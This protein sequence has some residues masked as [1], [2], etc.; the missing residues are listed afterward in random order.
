M[1]LSYGLLECWNARIQAVVLNIE[2]NRQ[3]YRQGDRQADSSTIHAHKEALRYAPVLPHGR[4]L[5]DHL[6]QLPS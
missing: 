2:D 4:T 6:R 1:T 5:W 3:T